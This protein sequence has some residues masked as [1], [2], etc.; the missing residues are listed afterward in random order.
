MPAMPIL[1]LNYA[2]KKVAL[3]MAA[4]LWAPN[5]QVSLEKVHK[6]GKQGIF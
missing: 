6:T 5:I 1:H 2:M 4:T 3:D